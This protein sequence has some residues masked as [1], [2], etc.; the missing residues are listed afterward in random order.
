MML[1]VPHRSGEEI[2]HHQHVVASRQERIDQV[3]PH[4]SRAASH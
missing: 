3:A 1:H 4:E 2:I